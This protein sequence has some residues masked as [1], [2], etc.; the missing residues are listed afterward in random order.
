MK[1]IHTL[2]LLFSV[3]HVGQVQNRTAN[4]GETTPPPA[5]VVTVYAL[6]GCRPCYRMQAEIKG[7]T[8][9][10]FRFVY[11][12]KHPRWVREAPMIV[13]VGKDGKTRYYTSGWEDFETWE[14]A[15]RRTN[16]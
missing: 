9:Y 14:A 13:W 6:R 1:T 4:R 16:P 12:P 5:P 7:H 15:Y 3:W 11:P 10:D 8:E 2:A